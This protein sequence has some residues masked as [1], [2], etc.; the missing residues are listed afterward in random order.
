M[1]SHLFFEHFRRMRAMTI[2]GALLSF[3]GFLQSEAANIVLWDTLEPL[4]ESVSWKEREDWKAV[5]SDLFALE[6]D[7]KKS[8]SDP[9]YYGR[10]Y[11]FHGDA[12]VENERTAVVF[13]SSKGKVTV[14]SS[15]NRELVAEIELMKGAI[16]KHFS[17]MRNAADQVMLEATFAK[18]SD[19]RKAIFV[20]G[21]DEIVEI[22]PDEKM[23]QISFTGPIEYGV[24]PGF[25]G[26]DLIFGGVE[27]EHDVIFVPSENLF[28]A[29]LN[30]ENKELVM[31]W[32][33]GKQQM[34]LNL[35]AEQDGK[36][37]IHS[38]EFENDGQSIYLAA[39]SAPGIWHREQLSPS[40]LEKQVE[41]QWKRPFPAKWQTQLT[42]SA[43]TTT[44]AFRESKGTVWR[45]V[46]GSYDYPVWFEGENAFY[47][48]S[49]KVPP[50][51]ESV[52]YFLEGQG[53]P[54]LVSTPVEIVKA[55]LGRPMSEPILDE[56]GRKLRTHH[57]RAGDGVRR[58]CTCGCTEAIQA[59]FEAGKEMESKDFINEALED[60]IY[61]VECHVG[62]IDEYR[63]F[64]DD[65]IKYLDSKA[66]STPEMQSY[67]DGLKQIV[68]QI[69]QEYNVQQ[70]NMKSLSYAHELVGKTM[71]LTEKKD[72]G[73][74]SAYMELLKAWRGMGGVQD[75]VVAQCHMITRKLFQEAGY[76]CGADPKALA[77]AQ[78]VRSR[79]R[80]VLRNPDGY[81]IWPNY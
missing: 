80:T 41:S 25:I 60:M 4:K 22:R 55:T 49:K 12:V 44:F 65:T 7:P 17:V 39:L 24:V 54:L 40:Y 38:V 72:A 29:L 76:S 70:E 19:E 35:G 71:A 73:N 27:S 62:R 31:T 10:E 15:G 18:G 59:V 46:P 9:G 57:R 3:E 28:L 45:G 30:G 5:P 48:L 75:Y 36:R 63:R 2:L 50:R 68:E 13:Q 21:R 16:I 20:L 6:V 58:A 52:I 67:I 77:L 61:F 37:P 11:T 33:K 47:H 66:K 81:E 53:T 1:N 32:P 42:E 43:V 23:R 51:G 74:V 8:S 64:A 79:C 34:K 14:F 69:P 26:D 56:A 78:D